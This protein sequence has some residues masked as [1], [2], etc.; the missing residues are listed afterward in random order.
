MKIL[1]NFCYSDDQSI[2]AKEY[3]EIMS[4]IVRNDLK[5]EERIQIRGYIYDSSLAESNDSLLDEMVPKMTADNFISI[6]QSL[7][8]DMIYIYRKTKGKDSWKNNEY[9]KNVAESFQLSKEVVDVLEKSIISDEEIISLRKN[10]KQIEN[11]VKEIAAQAGAVGMPLAAIYLSG[12]V[13]GVS[14]AGITSA[15]ASL[16][17]GGILGFSSM[18]TGIGVVALIGVGAYK[19]IRKATGLTDVEQ[20]KQRE[21]MLEQIIK[22]LQKTLSYVIEDVNS[23]SA[24]IVEETKKG[25]QSREKIEKLTSMLTM[26]T[27]SANNSVDNMDYME[28]EKII[29]KLPSELNYMKLVELTEGASFKEKRQFVLECYEQKV[30]EKDNEEVSVYVLKD[31]LSSNDLSALNEIFEQIGYFNLSTATFA[32]LKGNAKKIYN[33]FK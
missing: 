25:L 27:K 19:G 5:S 6:K 30:V 3:S 2:D 18:F 1:C 20:N 32:S 21:K 31:G 29:T 22:N 28:K 23:L 26:L 10:D 24:Q 13:V 8:K 12:S 4:L 14:A 16:G 7:I 11:S 9:I 15:L 33:S 17:C